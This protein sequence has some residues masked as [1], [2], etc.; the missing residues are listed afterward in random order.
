MSDVENTA[1]KEPTDE[2]EE[3]KKKINNNQKYNFF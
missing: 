3:P 1:N 2:K